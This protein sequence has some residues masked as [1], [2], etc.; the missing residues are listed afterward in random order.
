[1]EKYVIKASG[2]Q[3][4]FDI[5]KFQRSLHKAGASDDIIKQLAQEIE[6]R[7]DLRTTHDIYSFALKKLAIIQPPIAARYNLKNA[8]FEL[9]PT[10]FPFEH[11]ISHIFQALGYHTQTNQIIEGKCVAHEV[12]LVATTTQE[13][14]IAE[15]KFHHRQG[16]KVDIK[17]SLYVQARFEDIHALGTI[18]KQKHTN[19]IVTNTRFTTQTITYA[20]CVDITLLGWSYPEKDNIAQLIDRLGL[21]PITCLTSLTLRQKRELIAQNLVLCKDVHQHEQAL[22]NLHLSPEYVQRIIHEATSVCSR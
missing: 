20:Q 5:Q 8:L 15:C 10:G 17:V 12:D 14:I 4:A 2:E 6:Q 21:H 7:T 9:G 19:W 22:K 11:F 18:Q 16:L 3:E 13:H 1:M